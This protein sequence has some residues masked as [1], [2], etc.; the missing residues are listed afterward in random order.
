LPDPFGPISPVIVLDSTLKLTPLRAKMPPKL[1]YTFSILSMIKII[2]LRSSPL[3]QRGEC[4]NDRTM[5]LE[6]EK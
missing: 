1:L 4:W 6:E 5:A 3:K 2:S